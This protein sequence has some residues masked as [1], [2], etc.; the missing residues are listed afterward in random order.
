MSLLL[1]AGCRLML[2]LITQEQ[3][4]GATGAKPA[5]TVASSSWGMVTLTIWI[6]VSERGTTAQ[7]LNTK[8][9][10]VDGHQRTGP[11]GTAGKGTK[12]KVRTTRLHGERSVTNTARAR[13]LRSDVQRVLRAQHRSRGGLECRSLVLPQGLEYWSLAAWKGLQTQGQIG[14]ALN[15]RHGSSQGL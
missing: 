3:V 1:P 13:R 2:G 4:L 11:S 5:R 14:S 7:L 6:T 15:G 12:A 10:M 8:V 9:R